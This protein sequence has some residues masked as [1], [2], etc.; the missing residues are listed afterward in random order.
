[1]ARFLTLD[2]IAED[3]A[4]SRAQVHALV[5]SGDLPALKIGGRRQWRVDREAFEAWVTR[6]TKA[7]AAWV[8]RNPLHPGDTPAAEEH[9]NHG[10]A[11]RGQ[12][13]PEP[14]ANRTAPPDPDPHDRPAT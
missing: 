2:E 3:L 7:T 6:T 5:R 1:V 12:H 14:A 13:P 9:S 11:R 4:T 10:R 8:E